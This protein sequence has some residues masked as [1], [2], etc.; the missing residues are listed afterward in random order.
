[1]EKR[2]ELKNEIELT[3]YMKENATPHSTPLPTKIFDRSYGYQIIGFC[4]MVDLVYL[5]WM[6]IIDDIL[7]LLKRTDSY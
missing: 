5:A 4:V 6:N 7:F 2:K 3:E 1:M